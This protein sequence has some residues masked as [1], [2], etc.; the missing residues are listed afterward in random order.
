MTIYYELIRRVESGE[1]FCIDFKNK[2]MKVGKQFLIKNGEFDENRRLIDMIGDSTT[3]DDIIHH[4]EQEYQY[5][6]FSL[7]SERNDNKRKKYFKALSIDE[8]TDEQ[9]LYAHNREVAQCRLEGFILCAI[10]KNKFQWDEQKLGKWF[11]QSKND[12]DLVILRNWIE[13]K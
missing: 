4:I 13:N 1:A 3:L 12:P 5:Y 11:Y 8:L 7:P 9:M 2:T 10:L 6:K